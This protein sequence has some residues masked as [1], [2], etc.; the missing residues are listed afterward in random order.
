MFEN[1]PLW[2]KALAERGF[3]IVEG[4]RSAIEQCLSYFHE[5]L[6][7]LVR[8]R[9]FENVA[10][11][12]VF[13]DPTYRLSGAM[14]PGEAP[15]LFE[16]FPVGSFERAAVLLG[17]LGFVLDERQRLAGER[18]SFGLGSRNVSLSWAMSN[19]ELRLKAGDDSMVLPTEGVEVVLRD[20]AHR[21]GLFGGW[22]RLA[23]RRALAAAG[24]CRR[25]RDNSKRRIFRG[26]AERFLLQGP[27]VDGDLHAYDQPTGQQEYY[28]LSPS[29]GID[30]WIQQSLDAELRAAANVRRD[31]L[32]AP[33]SSFLR[34]RGW[35][36][37]T[38]EQCWRSAHR[39]LR[40]EWQR[41]GLCLRLEHWRELRSARTKLAYFGPEGEL[42]REERR[43]GDAVASA[44]VRR[45][46]LGQLKG[47]LG[48][49][50]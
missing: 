32:F 22:H 27:G 5:E 20:W 7:L 16:A 4:H 23:L 12:E 46:A 40:C 33:L 48:V 47:W 44:D 42:L 14:L 21:E 35:S 49:D 6:E 18:A 17:C 43:E 15:L 8:L 1:E 13:R 29:A 24:Y 31:G 11:V 26:N 38:V 25:L 19:P 45:W 41:R 50:G 9:I 34:E 28:G 10:R 3:G 2:D 36:A 39:R 37:R 30:R